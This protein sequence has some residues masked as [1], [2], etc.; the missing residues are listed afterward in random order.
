MKGLVL[1][2][3]IILAQGIPAYSQ[4][5]I[6]SE[7][8]MEYFNKGVT[9]MQNEDYEGADSL[10]TQALCTFKHPNVYYNRGVTRAFLNDTSGF[11]HDMGYLTFRHH[12]TVAG[13]YFNEICCAWVDTVYY[14][15]DF[16]PAS[17]EDHRYYEIKRQVEE[18]GDI[19][20]VIHDPSKFR[21]YAAVDF[22][23]DTWL[24]KMYTAYT[25]I[26]GSYMIINEN[27]YFMSSNS[28]P[29]IKYQDP[30]EELMDKAAVVFRNKYGFD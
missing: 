21:E 25:D 17:M 18:D 5:F 22:F 3:A 26:I 23:C 12:D 27:K 16:I 28:P 2:C 20:V 1:I 19:I 15:K 10:F 29:Y 24:P 9:L 4:L 6:D 11:C 8:G 13:N 30:Y 14:D 7:E